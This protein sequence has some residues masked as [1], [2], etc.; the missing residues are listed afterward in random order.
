MGTWRVRG[1]DEMACNRIS[2]LIILLV[3]WV[4]GTTG[5]VL[6][7]ANDVN[8]SYWTGKFPVLVVAHRGFSGSA[9]ENTLAAFQKA[10]EAGADAIE[11]DVRLSAD[12]E[13]VVIHDDAL[14][15]TTNGKGK[16]AAYSL[17]ELKRLDAGSWFGTQFSGERIPTLKEVLE[18]TKGRSLLNIELKSG[19]P[20]SYA[21]TDLAD[22]S[23]QAVQQA[24][25]LHQV[26]FS[27]F[28]PSGL[29]RIQ[30]RNPAIPTAL[31]LNQLW[32]FPRD[33]TGGKSFTMLNGRK[34]VV[35]SVNISRAH[36]EGIKIMVWTLNDE[37]EMEEFIALGVDGI[38]TN[39]PDRLIALLQKRS[40]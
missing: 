19:G 6:A 15:R 34:S 7:Q 30:Q 22:R 31:V 38:I 33:V 36:Q 8:P 28:D 26:L 13:I 29:E 10:V 18:L 5:T 35:N 9:P 27:S 40:R 20:G 24:G 17:L 4:G 23:L 21:I 12:G 32:T 3:L 37:K 14:D 11:L 39:Y 16:V 25:M 1:D 2:F